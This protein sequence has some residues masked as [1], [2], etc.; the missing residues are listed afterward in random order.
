MRVGVALHQHDH[1]Q[2]GFDVVGQARQA[3]RLGFDFVACGEHVFFHGPTVNAFVALAAAAG[4]TE[5]ISLLSSL[6]ILPL[7]PVGLAAKQAATLA[8][9]SGD[10]FE[11][12]IGVGGE[13]PPEFAA[14]GVPVTERGARTGEALP[15]LAALL[16]GERVTA[17]GRFAELD[18]L[19]LDPAPARR[20]PIWVGGRRAAAMERA[21]AHADVWLPYL[22]TP[23]R[24]ADSLASV[25][26]VA[27]RHGRDPSAVSG[28]LFV[29]GTVDEDAD[30]ARRSAI[31]FVS[32]VYAQDFAP[33]AD[34]YLVAGDPGQ[35]TA[36][37]AEYRDAGA[38]SV[39][40][41][42]ACPV[43]DRERMIETLAAGV[44]PALQSAT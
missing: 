33:L 4:A 8:L 11:L 17:S 41:S 35:V 23:Q 34:K 2:G 27:A 25:R 18:G 7:Y 40:F 42:P 36:R 1:R 6:T 28:A 37:L 21:G 26:E 22:V 19:A 20:P 29:W 43:A 12:G 32:E 44:L 13:Y 9:V 15:V 16:A 24:F 14:C 3:E 30:R 5:R 38:E 10:R 31:S 39:I